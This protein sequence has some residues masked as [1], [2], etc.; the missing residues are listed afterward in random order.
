[1][2]PKQTLIEDIDKYIK[3]IKLSEKKLPS[4]IQQFYKIADI[5]DI[6]KDLPS[7]TTETIKPTLINT[8]DNNDT[9]NINNTSSEEIGYPFMPNLVN[10][11]FVKD[12]E[13]IPVPKSFIRQYD[14]QP[15]DLITR[16][17]N[18][19]KIDEYKLI[20]KVD[21]PLPT[22]VIQIKYAIITNEY[23]ELRVKEYINENS[24][25]TPLDPNLLNDGKD[26]ITVH[27]NDC[28]KFNLRKDDI[29]DIAFYAYN[30]IARISW[31]HN[32]M[33]S[34]PTPKKSGYYKNKESNYETSDELEG[35]TIT[36]LGGT[37]I[38]SDWKEEIT[39]LGGKCIT[40]DSNTKYT[41]K[42]HIKK[43]DLV[44]IPLLQTSHAKSILG[45]QLAKEYD[46]PVINVDGVGRSGFIREVKNALNI[47]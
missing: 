25:R 20:K 3:T 47:D 28:E 15:G 4:Q 36:I 14:L 21:T 40:T 38:H 24:E 10:G 27:T 7:N 32:D 37:S 11:Y 26:Y 39:K 43:S 12:G 46:I 45:N 42:N 33:R 30:D 18:E 13:T 17:E 23:G 41:L 5:L 22:N 16:H 44:V 8:E 6:V 1:M 35:K 31:V 2:N 9:T 34:L 19:S 29:V